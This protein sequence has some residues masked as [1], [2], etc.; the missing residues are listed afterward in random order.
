MWSG[1]TSAVSVLLIP[2][3]WKRFQVEYQTAGCCGKHVVEIIP[4]LPAHTQF[5]SSCLR[6]IKQ[7]VLGGWKETCK[8]ASRWQCRLQH[9]YLHRDL[10]VWVR[11]N[12]DML[13]STSGQQQSV[14]KPVLADYVHIGF[15][16]NWNCHQRFFPI[17]KVKLWCKL[18]TM[19][20]ERERGWGEISQEG[21]GGKIH[22]IARKSLGVDEV[23]Q[24]WNAL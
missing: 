10:S 2:Q 24:V 22:T 6:N 19:T 13:F 1:T 18:S 15:L 9:K 8:S 7:D 21:T 12:L 11:D 14:P 3:H 4:P 23:W 16:S 17:Y 20:C 5:T